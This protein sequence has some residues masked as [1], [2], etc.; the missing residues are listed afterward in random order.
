MSPSLLPNGEGSARLLS[1]THTHSQPG[2]RARGAHLSAADRQ[3][4]VDDLLRR[5]REL[6]GV[7]AFINAE[8]DDD[9]F[10]CFY[11]L[12][13]VVVVFFRNVL[14]KSYSCFVGCC[15]RY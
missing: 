15:Y 10:L 9:D 7:P 12:T 14:H 13:L 4:R 1:L 3:G 11:L 2:H 6:T 8:R 5:V